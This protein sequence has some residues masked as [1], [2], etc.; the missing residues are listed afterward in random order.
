M[1]TGRSDVAAL[2]D[3]NAKTQVTLTG[4]KPTVTV[5]LQQGRP[6]GMYTLT[7]GATGTAPSG[8]VLEGSNDGTTWSPVDKRTGVT[9]PWTSYTRSFSIASPKAYTQ[10]RLVLTPAGADGVT[11]AEF[12][13]LGTL[14]GIE[15]GTHPSDRRI[16]ETQADADTVAVDRPQLRIGQRKPGGA[17]PER[18]RRKMRRGGGPRP[19]CH[20]FTPIDGRNRR[21]VALHRKS[22][23]GGQ[24]HRLTRLASTHS[25]IATPP[26]GTANEAARPG[27]SIAQPPRSAHTAARGAGTA[28]RTGARPPG[29][30]RPLGTSPCRSTASACP[31][32]HARRTTGPWLEGNYSAGP[33][34]GEEAGRPDRGQRYPDA[35][36]QS[37]EPAM[38]VHD[39]RQADPERPPQQRGPGQ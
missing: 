11:L 33:A 39:H 13:L 7:N 12:E 34:A 6:V 19:D 9:W 1:V 21:G 36:V 32:R 23:H 8:W 18:F 16:A 31:W 15:T 29:R 5:A 28:Q 37:P 20:P 17:C 2:T 14:K 4:D 30:L 38:S 35:E 10:Y 22:P 26:S 3:N 27:R 24:T 25:A